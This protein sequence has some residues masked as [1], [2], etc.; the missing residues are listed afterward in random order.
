MVSHELG[1]KQNLFVFSL[2][3]ENCL[4]CHRMEK[5]LLNSGSQK[6]I[7]EPTVS[8]LPWNC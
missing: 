2:N 6:I 4:V 7:F 1:V 3:I 8:T 5:V